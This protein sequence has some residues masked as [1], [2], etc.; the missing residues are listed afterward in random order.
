MTGRNDDR[1][2]GQALVE[3]AVVIPLILLLM[4][5]LFDA[6]RAVIFYTELTNASRVGARVA[7]VNQ[8]DDAT[9]TTSERTYKCAASE[10]ATSMGIPASS[11]PAAVFEDKD[12]NNV[13]PD[14]DVC[15]TY[16]ACSATVS[17]TYAFTPITPII[18]NIIG[19]INLS[20]S[21]TMAIERTYS[22]PANP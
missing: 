18:G 7:M 11:I 4:L 3:F 8:S 12:G 10:L 17:A 15:L 5:A 19:D 14:A 16:G 6:G 13:A 2:R 21:T 1:S 22:S 9:C 20:A